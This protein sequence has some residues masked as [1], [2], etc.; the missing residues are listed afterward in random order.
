[1]EKADVDFIWAEQLKLKRRNRRNRIKESSKLDLMMSSV[2]REAKKSSVLRNS[3]NRKRQRVMD[4]NRSS[5]EVEGPS[6]DAASVS[7]EDSMMHNFD[8][9]RRAEDDVLSE[10]EI[11]NHIE[12]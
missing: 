4:Q 5:K 10:G 6:N 2:I 9:T 1:M 8:T 7:K 3:K 12:S 11:S